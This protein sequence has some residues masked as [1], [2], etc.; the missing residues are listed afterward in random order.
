M[1]KELTW[2]GGEA[3]V[4]EKAPSPR[5]RGELP[6]GE[7]ADAAV[8]PAVW[9]SLAESKRCTPA[10]DTCDSAWCLGQQACRH[11]RHSASHAQMLMLSDEGEHLRALQVMGRTALP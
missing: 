2:G 11:C 3:G 6:K 4:G 5:V 9:R 7:A 10:D 1:V 8:G